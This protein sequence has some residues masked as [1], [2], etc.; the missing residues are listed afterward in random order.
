MRGWM[1][2]VLIL[3]CIL[4][5]RTRACASFVATGG[6]RVLV[7]N[8]RDLRPSEQTALLFFVPGTENRYG[9]MFWGRD[10]NWIQCGTNE[11]GLFLDCTGV[12]HLDSYDHVGI[13][14]PDPLFTMILDGCA[15]VEEAVAVFRRYLLPQLRS[16]HYFVA[17]RSGA[18]A[19]VEWDGKELRV[20]PKSGSYQVMT[21]FRLTDPQRGGHPCYRYNALL[22]IL[23]EREHSPALLREALDF[24]HQ[25]ELTYYSNIIDLGT[26][27]ITVFGCHNF[28]CPRSL[29]LS[30]ELEKGAH[31]YSMED[32]FPQRRVPMSRLERR[33]GMICEIGSMKPFSGICFFRDSDGRLRKEGLVKEGQCTGCWKYFDEDGACIHED[34]YRRLLLHYDS[35]VL[36][37]EGMLKNNMMCGAWIWFHEDGQIAMK[38]EAIDGIFYRDDNPHP[39][40]GKL[41][42]RFRNGNPCSRRSFERGLLEGEAIDWYENGHVRMEGQFEEGRHEGQWRSYH[43]DGSPERIMVYE[44]HQGSPHREFP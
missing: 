33:N 34:Q 14:T 18:A 7:G 37:A 5:M 27:Q 40:S 35:G 25:E 31:H 32:L 1:C 20:L 41:E 12:P 26:G 13:E 28:N 42:L 23:R 16:V 39:Y 24:T 43:R 38:G 8:N 9:K 29:S 36:R 2:A 10:E 19:I 11:A 30:D 15:T 17:D 21:N 6:G 3:T 22:R 4:P 44:D